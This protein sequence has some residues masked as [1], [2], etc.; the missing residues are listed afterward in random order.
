[1]KPTDSTKTEVLKNARSIALV[2]VSPEHESPSFE[3]AAYLQSQGYDLIPVTQADDSIL[4]FPTVPSLASVSKPADAVAVFLRS[5][6]EGA[7]PADLG[8]LGIKAIWVEPQCSPVVEN[9]CRQT[10][11]QVFHDCIMDDHK[12]LLADWDS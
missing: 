9:A 1:M 12:R 4:G 7:I 11:V 3:V 6:Q 5:D 8:N 10:G 2:G